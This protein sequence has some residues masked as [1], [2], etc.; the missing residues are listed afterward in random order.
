MLA[1]RT[2]V[3]GVMV[4]GL[5]LGL[6][7]GGGAFYGRSTAKPIAPATAA[8]AG[9]G[10]AGGGGAG[11]GAGGAAAAARPTVG[12]IE[13]VSGATLTL[14]TQAGQTTVTLASDATV[15]QTSSAQVS[16]L[17]PGLSVS[18]VGTTE[19]DGKVTARAVTITPAGAGGPTGGQR[20]AASPTPGR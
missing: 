1:F 19:S 5:G 6:A 2:L 8:P 17:R 12:V 18:V 7:F 4:F 16:D 10:G 9:G 11:G 14:R 3:I 13:S 15:S 20:P